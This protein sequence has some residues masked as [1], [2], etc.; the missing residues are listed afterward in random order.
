[1]PRNRQTKYPIIAQVSGQWKPSGH[2][3][4][5]TIAK[6]SMQEPAT[7]GKYILAQV[8]AYRGIGL[9]SGPFW[10]AST[11]NG[12]SRISLAKLAAQLKLRPFKTP[13]ANPTRI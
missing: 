2:E 13:E 4:R 6:A 10:I 1:M 11:P 5:D 7:C 9:M 8:L 3:R 12:W